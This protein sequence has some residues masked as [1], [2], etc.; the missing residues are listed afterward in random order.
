MP[1]EWLVTMWTANNQVRN[2]RW[3][4]C[5]TVPAV[6]EVCLRQPAHWKVGRARR[7]RQPLRL[8]Q[9]GQTKP[10]GQRRSTR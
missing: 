9:C 7:S 6:T 2:G 5:M 3:L 10:S 4:R 8:R 1:L